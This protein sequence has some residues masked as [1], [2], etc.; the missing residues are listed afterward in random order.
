MSLQRD[1]KQSFE[2]VRVDL[3]FVSFQ[4]G[5]G[6]WTEYPGVDE[7]DAY[8]RARQRVRTRLSFFRHLATFFAVIFAVVLIDL[9]TGGGISQIVLWVTGIWGAILVWQMFN[10]FVF[11]MVWSRETEE[12]MIQEELRKQHNDEV[13]ER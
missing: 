10:V 12:R 8:E 13:V 3:P 1:D 2:G 7:D 6:G 11:P 5:R 4:I 9:V